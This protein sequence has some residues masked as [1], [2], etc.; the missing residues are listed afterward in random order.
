MSKKTIQ[1]LN[2]ILL[3][4]SLV[5]LIGAG[6]YRVYMLNHTGILSTLAV[7]TL[8]FL[9]ILFF[10]LKS[11]KKH[12]NQKNK[13]LA[14]VANKRLILSLAFAYL[15][16]FI[17]LAFIAFKSRTDETI[18]SIWQVVP[19]YFFIIYIVAT[20]L[21]ILLIRL[22]FRFSLLA[23]IA[24][25]FL[26]FTLA[27]VVYR[28][29]QG[30]DPFIH[31]ATINLIKQNGLVEPKPPYYLGYYSLVITLNYLSH[32]SVHALSIIL[33]P[34]LAAVYIPLFLFRALKNWFAGQASINMAILSCLI[35]PFG[36]FALT[37]PQSLAWLLFLLVILYGLVCTNYFD[38]IFIYIIALSALVI[39]PI[40]GIPAVLFAVIL[41]IY[42]SEF[43]TGKIYLYFPNFLLMAVALPLSFASLGKAFSS[44]GPAG[45]INTWS[46]LTSKFF[47][48]ITA[49]NSENIILN[50]VYTFIN[51]L[52]WLILLLFIAGVIIYFKNKKFCRIFPLYISG[53]LA[54]IAGLVLLGRASFAYLIE[55]EQT[56][57]LAR[58]LIN[59]LI[60]LAPL[61]IVALYS[62]AAKA[63]RLKMPGQIIMAIVLSFLIAASLYASYPRHD[64]YFNSHGH[65][66][67]QAD[68]EAVRW[69]ENNAQG[70]YVVL[71]NQQVSAAALSQFGFKKYFADNIFYYPIPT[72]SPLYKYYL[73]MVQDSPKRDTILNAME[74]VG[75]NQAYLV[76]NKYW[77][78]F[79]KIQAEARLEADSYESIDDGEVMI[80]KYQK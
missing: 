43:K 37:T 77:W 56:N 68:I 38:L 47:P 74:L 11:N 15:I 34:L 31:E 21:L 52:P 53:S 30:F 3:W 18:I 19:A 17:A 61:F 79:P 6:I 23:V 65:S 69:I 62:A 39:Q 36:L 40:A 45:A 14:A 72:S 54:M 10:R 33:T 57:Y 7:S 46:F 9:I 49:P 28:L 22:K 64:N 75:V 16:C 20:L 70:D 50:L 48:A 32:I 42:H 12:P 27:L 67:G 44:S 59:A 58:L 41:T 13:P 76:L 66:I 60:F 51:N 73:Q 25:Y 78:A 5:S 1:V 55:Y 2:F 71:A 63:R 35:I 26:S 29:G 80:F 8:I 24:H 4:L